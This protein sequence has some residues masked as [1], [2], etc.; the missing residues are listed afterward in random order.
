[1]KAESAAA[2][3]TRSARHVPVYREET[4]EERNNQKKY[5]PAELLN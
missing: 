1:M 3:M 5:S 4:K 2:H